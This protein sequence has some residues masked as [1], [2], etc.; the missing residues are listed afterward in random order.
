[1]PFNQIPQVVKPLLHAFV[2]GILIPGGDGDVPTDVF[3]SC[4]PAGAL[5][6]IRFPLLPVSFLSYPPHLIRF[7][8]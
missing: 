5:L 6:I 4:L 2:A 7:L 1:M 8:Q 3:C